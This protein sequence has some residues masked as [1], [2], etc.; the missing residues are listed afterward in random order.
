[1]SVKPCP[2]A[3]RGCVRAGAVLFLVLLLLVQGCGK[4]RISPPPSTRYG[5]PSGS[6]VVA[7]ARSQLGRPYKYGGA[8]P[9]AGFDCSGLI[10]WSY[11]QHGVAVPRIATEQAKAGSVVKKSQLRQGDIVVFRIS[12]RTGIHTGLYSGNGKFIHSPSSGKR[13]REDSMNDDYWKRR[14]I[15]GRRVI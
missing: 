8:S 13:I 10:H 11:K 1:M 6:A 15:S 4:A 7:A 12:S 3:A 2:Y 5:A 9:Q 14:Y